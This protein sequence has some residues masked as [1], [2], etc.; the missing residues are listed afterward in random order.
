MGDFDDPEVWHPKGFMSALWAWPHFINEAGE[1]IEESKNA[2]R[3][4]LE[5]ENGYWEIEERENVYWKNGFYHW[6]ALKDE[7]RQ[8]NQCSLMF[9]FTTHLGENMMKNAAAIW[10]PATNFSYYIGGERSREA[11]CTGNWSFEIPMPQKDIGYIWKARQVIGELDGLKIT[12][13]SVYLSPLTLV[14]IVSREGG[15]VDV[16]TE[17]KSMR[18]QELLDSAVTLNTKDGKTVDLGSGYGIG[19]ESW[20]RRY[21]LMDVID[22]AEFQGGTL[23]LD[24]SCGKVTLPLDDLMPVEP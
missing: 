7:D 17:E 19:M 5:R 4:I 13:E 1:Q 14:I 20:G 11:V 6:Q 12:L 21:D 9:R 16:W 24:L 22:P 15:L 3:V 2:S 18:W 23:V 10:I 8:D